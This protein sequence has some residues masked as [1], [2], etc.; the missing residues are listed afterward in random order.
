MPE[1]KSLSYLGRAVAR[2]AVAQSFLVLAP[3]AIGVVAVIIGMITGKDHFSFCTLCF[4][5]LGCE[6]NPA[7]ET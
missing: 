4:T 3:L 1:R 6:C 2:N 7:H 5:L